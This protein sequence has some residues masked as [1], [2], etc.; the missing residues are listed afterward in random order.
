MGFSMN[1]SGFPGHTLDSLKLSPSCFHISLAR[2]VL[3]ELAIASCCS[4]DNKVRMFSISMLFRTF[5][6]S[7]SLLFWV[8]NNSSS[9]EHQ[10]GIFFFQKVSFLECL[11]RS[12]N[13]EI[14]VSHSPCMSYFHLSI[15]QL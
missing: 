6:L 5:F 12:L 3:T 13:L 15:Y 1:G 7:L 2:L 10:L 9:D 14:V 8:T 11:C 4:T